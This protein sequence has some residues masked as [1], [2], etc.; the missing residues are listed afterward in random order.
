MS[1]MKKGPTKR[2]INFNIFNYGNSLFFTQENDNKEEEIDFGKKDSGS[3]AFSSKNNI[4]YQ[5]DDCNKGE[6]NLDELGINEDN[7]LPAKLLKDDEEENAFDENND[8]KNEDEEENPLEAQ[9]RSQEENPEKL[10][11]LTNLLTLAKEQGT[12]RYLQQ[13]IE[14]EPELG[15][16]YFYPTII[17]HINDLII[18][19][20]GNYLIQKVIKYLSENQKTEVL[21]IA[22]PYFL[23]ICVNFY[24][25]RVIQKLIEEIH[26]ETLMTN[27][28]R[29]INHSFTALIT[30]INGTHIIM[31]L[32]SIKSASITNSLCDSI[33][34]NL[35]EIA[36]NKHGCCVIQKIIENNS[37]L[38]EPI[39]MN[40]I[41][42]CTALITHQYGN[43]V[44]QYVL[45]LNNQ[46]YSIQ[47]INRLVPNFAF[48]AKQKYSSTVIE[49]CFELCDNQS[50]RVLYQTI[51]NPQMM[52]HL[53]L[54]KYGNY[55][56]QKALECSDDITKRYLLTMIAPMLFELNKLN[57]G[58][59][60]YNKLCFK[61]PLLQE[62]TFLISN[63]QQQRVQMQQ[64]QY[65]YLQQ[66]QILKFNQINK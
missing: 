36:M 37:S 58:K 10:M 57:F 53:L 25:T 16:C 19:P 66:Q 4:F 14:E 64:H 50:R 59:Q 63:T 34:S 7:I 30:D 42:N 41:K 65:Q 27:L 43:Y 15:T 55:V 11:L 1:L 52:K 28:I 17:S 35:I 3:T 18:H 8:N 56:T 48:L 5:E 24:G 44:V 33:N 49:K 54:D 29:I 46:H 32:L 21:S 61:Y 9:L 40:I 23:V 6:G 39:I 51:A 62:I 31:K 47:I 12:C 20:F 60:L 22:E 38:F 26:T 13:R 2:E 45:Q